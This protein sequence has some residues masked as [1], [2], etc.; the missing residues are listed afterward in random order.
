[1]PR[2]RCRYCL[3]CY[4][5]TNNKLNIITKAAET[6]A[7]AGIQEKNGKKNDRK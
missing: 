2:T 4:I 6:P 5:A 7:A 1:M 3:Y